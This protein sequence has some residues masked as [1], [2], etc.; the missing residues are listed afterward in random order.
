[1]LVCCEVL[2]VWSC[3]M[4]CSCVWY[5]DDPVVIERPVCFDDYCLVRYVL[6]L[7][8]CLLFLLLYIARL[9]C[10]DIP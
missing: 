8:V 10:V 9:F 3:L 6:S 7:I 1:M 5:C 2:R 4:S